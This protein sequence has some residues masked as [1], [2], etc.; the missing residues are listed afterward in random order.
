MQSMVAMAPTAEAAPAAP[1]AMPETLA[2]TADDGLL[3]SAEAARMESVRLPVTPAGD[4]LSAP[5]HAF[6]AAS[7]DKLRKAPELAIRFMNWVAA[8][9]GSGEIRHNESGSLVHFCDRGALLLTPEIFRRFVQTYAGGADGSLAAAIAEGEDKAIA[10]VQSALRKAGWTVRNGDQNIHYYTFPKADGSTSRRSAF[11]LI[12]V[13]QLF[14]NPVPLPNPRLQ[15]LPDP[16]KR[17]Q[18]TA[19]G[20]ARETRPRVA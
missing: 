14:W 3:A 15:R 9:V 20:G 7:T 18:L 8:A 11:V 2:A 6:D 5:R 16:P 4:A 10:R 17:L 1:A 12:G 13:P 19:A